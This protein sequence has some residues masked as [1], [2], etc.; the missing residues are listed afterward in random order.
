MISG[1][2]S[3]VGQMTIRIAKE[4]GAGRVIA[5]VVFSRRDLK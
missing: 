3:G 2:Q 4:L 1:A 5:V